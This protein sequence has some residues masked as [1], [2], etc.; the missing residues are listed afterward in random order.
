MSHHAAEL[1]KHMGVVPCGATTHPRSS[2]DLLPRTLPQARH[3]RRLQGGI[4]GFGMCAACEGSPGARRALRPS[5]GLAPLPDAPPER[6]R[7]VPFTSGWN[8]CKRRVRV[9][10]PG[11][12][13]EAL[14]QRR[15][16][17]FAGGESGRCDSAWSDPVPVG[18]CS[19]GALESR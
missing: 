10:G 11:L 18:G 17:A 4:R 6:L 14:V 16:G 8:Y 19:R 1:R 7:Q 9:R 5:I 15:A 13:G 12:F 3:R 2:H